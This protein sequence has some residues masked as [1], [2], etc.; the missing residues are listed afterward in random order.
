MS[1]TCDILDST[2][3]ESYWVTLKFSRIIHF[4][5]VMDGDRKRSAGRR[6]LSSEA[7]GF[8]PS[9]QQLK[10]KNMLLLPFNYE[11]NIDISAKCG[12]KNVRNG[13]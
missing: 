1:E 13:K 9:D 7:R 8:L 11:L 6:F 10:A 4:I 3:R 12:P 5:S 2:A